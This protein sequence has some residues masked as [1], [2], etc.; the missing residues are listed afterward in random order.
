MS[1]F[2]FSAE[3]IE[4]NKLDLGV[5]SCLSM[6]RLAESGVYLNLKLMKWRLMPELNLDKNANLKCLL[7]GA[8]TLGCS[9]ARN[10]IVSCIYFPDLKQ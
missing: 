8:G 3:E 7:F 5:F 10:L 9:V 6:N 4:N 1:V 2:L